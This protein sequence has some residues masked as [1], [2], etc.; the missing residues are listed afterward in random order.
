MKYTVY[1]QEGT[2][3]KDMELNPAVFEVPV[4]EELV[5]QVLVAQEA[6]ARVVLAHTKQRGEVRG[7]GRK[8]HR[9]KGTGRAR[10]G[11][12]RSP[13]W[14]GGA[15]TF[16][17]RND[18]NFSK[19]I[20]KKMKRKA[21]FMVLSDKATDKQIILL[22]DLKVEEQKTKSFVE[23]MNGLFTKVVDKAD[24]KK[25]KFEFKTLIVC[26]GKNE[27][28]VKSS[29]NLS[30]V[31]AVRADSLNVKDVINYDWLIVPIQSLKV[32]E[33]TYLGVE[34]NPREQVRK[35]TLDNVA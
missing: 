21:L 25:G 15:I 5:H 28:L 29:N 9:Q 14:K 26:A 18:R 4:K 10:A 31:K 8:P 3:V 1:N 13:L 12:N 33:D 7:G 19:K 30:K 11:S 23:A 2:K 32:I 16:G 27:N 20:N 17:P 22:D 34:A 6:N 35:P 24:Q